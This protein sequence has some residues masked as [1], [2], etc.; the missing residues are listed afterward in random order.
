MTTP[1]QATGSMVSVIIP[2]LNAADT[3]PSQLSALAAQTYDQAWEVLV[4]DNG[5]SDSTKELVEQTAAHFP[6]PL[7]LVDASQRRGSCHARNTGAVASRGDLLLFC[8]ADDVV[9]HD[10]IARGADA[11]RAADLVAGATRELRS[12]IDPDAPLVH[13]DVWVG[14]PGNEVVI[15]SNLGVR[16]E[17]YFRAGG[18]DESLPPYGCHDIEFGL[19]VRKCGGE[20]ARE[21]RM[22]VFFRRTTGTRALL[23][24]VYRSGRTEPLVWDRHPDLF[25]RDRSLGV[26]VRQLAALPISLTRNAVRGTGEQPSQGA[27]ELVVRFGH[28]AAYL[29]GGTRSNDRPPLLLTPAD[30][31]R[32]TPHHE[33]TIR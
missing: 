29:P 15:S 19:R 20:V 3:L 25:P 8:D 30:D 6:V 9:D 5:S 33:D 12:P 7:R 1:N 4:A 11:L 16:R 28:V 10:W 13:P 2:A 22:V 18:F 21:P 27:R 14:R 24:K 17:F 32:Q 23:R 31:P 26:A